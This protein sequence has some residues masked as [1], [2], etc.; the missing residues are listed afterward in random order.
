LPLLTEIEKKRK[1]Q[2]NENGFPSDFIHPVAGT[3]IIC[4]PCSYHLWTDGKHLIEY[5]SWAA[6]G[7]LHFVQNLPRAGLPL[8]GKRQKSLQM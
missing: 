7:L 8:P 2:S 1:L 6:S 3:S 4:C 5:H